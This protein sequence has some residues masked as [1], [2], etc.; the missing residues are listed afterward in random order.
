M[1]TAGSLLTLNSYNQLMLR[2]LTRYLNIES[3]EDYTWNSYQEGDFKRAVSI[4][5]SGATVVDLTKPL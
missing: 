1:G 3:R 2:G 5:I 4:V